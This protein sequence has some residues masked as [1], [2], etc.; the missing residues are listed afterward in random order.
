M[1]RVNEL[2]PIAVGTVPLFIESV[3]NPGLIPRWKII[4]KPLLVISM[5]EVALNIM[6]SYI[7]TIG[8][9]D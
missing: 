6:I 2:A 1:G 7:L 9:L 5:G 4:L 3:A 8:T